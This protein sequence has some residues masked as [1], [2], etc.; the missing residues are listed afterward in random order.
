MSAQ[1]ALNSPISPDGLRPLDPFKDLNQVA[2]LIEHA[3]AGELEP[4]GQRSLQDLRALA[5]MGPFTQWLARSD[6]YLQDVLAGFVWQ[7]DG[8]VV[9]N[10]TLQRG[11]SYGGRWQIANVA[12]DKNWRGRG[13]GR[14]LMEAALARI[15]EQ[16]GSWA[17]L[18]VRTDN[19]A[20]LTLYQHL[21]FQPLTEE[22]VLQ[23]DQV[24]AAAPAAEPIAG[25]RAY[26][27]SE[28]QARYVLESSCRSELAQWWRPLRSH[29]FIQV[30]E[31][32]L[33]EKFW[34]LAGRN[35]IRRW[36]LDGAHGGLAAWLEVDA[37]R[38]N[39]IHR[40]G[41][42]V[43]PALRGRTE[44]RLLG[45]LLTFLDDYPRWPVR[46]EHSGEHP[47]MIEALH[48]VGFHLVRNHMAMRRK[49]A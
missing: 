37:R 35:R 34:E 25:L 30:T 15:E 29:N 28:W 44:D 1:L 47:Q 14:A 43:H 5:R 39:G 16:H 42:T 33:G 31:S 4:S 13:I 24:P 32:R 26:H 45:H 7:G 17:V 6:P 8:R 27:H 36:T 22:L 49:M 12:V 23:L 9:G 48:A 38:W 3:F 21:G 10:I 11:D 46:I 40:L 2:D 19:A 41:V 20:A 18:Q